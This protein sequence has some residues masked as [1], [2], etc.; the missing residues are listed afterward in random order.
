MQRLGV[1]QRI[2]PRVAPDRPRPK[3]VSNVG[4]IALV[5]VPIGVAIFAPKLLV[6]VIV[7]YV[8]AVS[9]GVVV[10]WWGQFR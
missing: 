3:R 8:V 7:L 4:V 2:V 9:F 6:A 1:R 5:A 10:W